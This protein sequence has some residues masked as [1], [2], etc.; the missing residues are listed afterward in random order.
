M[1]SRSG[2][3]AARRVVIKIG[4]ALLARDRAC[5]GQIAHDVKSLRN[6]G[7]EVVLVS[8]GAVALG[9]SAL[10]YSERPGDLAG[11][12]AAAAAGQGEL[13]SRWGQALSVFDLSAAQVLLTHADLQDRRRYLNARSA[14]LRLI[15]RGVVPVVNEND[16]VSV[17]ELRFGDNDELAAEV[18]GL[19]SADL[20]ILLTVAD[21]LYTA[22]PSEDPSARLV[23]VVHGIDDAILAMAGPPAKF[24][25][26]GMVTKVAAAQIAR[27]HGAA[28]VIAPGA[29]EGVVLSVLAGDDVGTLFVG[30]KEPP[31]RARKRWIATTLRPDGVVVVDAGAKQALL[32]AASL[33]MAGVREVRGAFARGDVV[34]V[35]AQGEEV[36]FARGITTLSAEQARSVMGLKSAQVREALGGLAPSE[37]ISRDDL[38]L[39]SAPAGD[40][41]KRALREERTEG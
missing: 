37:L 33:L 17:E 28:T 29:K 10:G 39:L 12:Q 1:R 30:P 18:C 21:G 32:G 35:C 14:L 16:T 36:P 2:L 38:A 25:T 40:D 31:E 20:V 13:L 8:S 3:S 23:P 26:G 22:D 15:E 41:E 19:V 4:S 24:G 27:R 6:Q 7:I 11:L 34:D 9:L 5:F